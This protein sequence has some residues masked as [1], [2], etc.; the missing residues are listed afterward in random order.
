VHELKSAREKVAYSA[1]TSD[2]AA[3]RVEIVVSSDCCTIDSGIMYE[4]VCHA[5]CRWSPTIRMCRVFNVAGRCAECGCGHRQHV[6]SSC[7]PEVTD[8]KLVLNVGEIERRKDQ[9]MDEI[10][11]LVD[12]CAKLATFLRDN[13]FFGGD[14]ISS[15]VQ[16]ELDALGAA[17]PADKPTQ[18]ICDGLG[19]VLATN[20]HQVASLAAA[21]CKYSPGDVQEMID[22]LFVHACF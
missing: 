1:S 19:C 9:S 17:S 6:W 14:V 16:R 2:L 18:I 20:R 7:V 12:T 11:T 15:G 22:K 5:R 3:R 13:S 8:V 10:T 4:R 21:D